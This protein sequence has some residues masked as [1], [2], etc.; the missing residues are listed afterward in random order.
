LSVPIRKQ[1]SASS[2]NSSRSWFLRVVRVLL[3]YPLAGVFAY[4]AYAKFVDVYTFGE[5]LRSYGVLPD[6]LIKPLA[7]LLPIAEALIALGLI[8]KLTARYAAGASVLLSLFF[9]AVL[10]A[11]FGE[12]MPLGCGCFGPGQEQTVGWDDVGKDL[13]FALA[14]G[15]VLALT[16]PLRATR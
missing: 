7:I 15:L 13:L 12:V 6:G 16:R 9:A 8:L 5:V 10:F 11:K 3:Q 2:S 14:G 1:T 4:S